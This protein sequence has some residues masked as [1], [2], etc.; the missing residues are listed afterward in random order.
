MRQKYQ[1]FTKVKRALLQALLRDF[2]TQHIKKGETID[3]FFSCTLTIANKMKTHCETMSP[4]II[5]EKILRFMTL[6]FDYMVC[7][8]KESSYLNTLTIDEL[9]SSLFIHEQRMNIH[10]EEEQAL[11]ITHEDNTGR[12]RDRGVFRERGRGRGPDRQPFNK[13]IIEC[14]KCHKLGH[15]QYECPSW[16]NGAN[17]T[18]IDEREELLLISYVELNHAKRKEV[19][20]FD[21]GCNNHMSRNKEW[22]LDLDV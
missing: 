7:S 14:F 11:K 6:K 16:E 1:S 17:Y 3:N 18:E 12:G 9:Q 5:N 4:T 2:E 20:F 22:F 19:W 21:S 13:A 10:K 15:F 8:I